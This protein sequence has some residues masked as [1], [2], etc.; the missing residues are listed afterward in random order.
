MNAIGTYPT[1]RTGNESLS[2]EQEVAVGRKWILKT[3]DSP[4]GRRGKDKDRYKREARE[5][6]QP[7]NPE[8]SDFHTA[9]AASYKALTD[10]CLRTR[11]LAP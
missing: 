1:P 8:K 4:L 2:Y 10:V 11:L 9:P 6:A 5:Q 7:Q 3:A